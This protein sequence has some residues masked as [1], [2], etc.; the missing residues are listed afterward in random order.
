MAA[1]GC[2]H[3]SVPNVRNT[4]IAQ[5]A[6][7]KAAANSK[8]DE[9]R[10][11]LAQIPDPQKSHYVNVQNEA[12]WANPFIEVEPDM[13]RVRILLADANPSQATVGTF[14]RPVAARRRVVVIRPADLAEMLVA[15]PSTS[16]PYGRVVALA[17]TREGN[18]K[19][20]AAMRRTEEQTIKT[21]NDLGVIAEDWTGNGR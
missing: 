19:D 18:R 13:L 6:K 1:T 9:Q 14:I 11:E 21:L 5:E 7:A 3:A 2:E 16:W 4:P 8:L 12:A 17:E 15:V 20:V 10:T